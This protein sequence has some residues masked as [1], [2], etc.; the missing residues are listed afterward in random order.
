MAIRFTPK[1]FQRFSQITR[2]L[3]SSPSTLPVLPFNFDEKSESFV[4][5]KPET[6]TKTKTESS[7]LNFENTQELF[8]TFS[9]TKLIRSVFN[10]N[11]ASIDPVVDMGIWVMRSKLL[12]VPGFRQAILG[13]VKHSFYEQ[14]VAGKDLKETSETVQKLYGDGLRGMLNYGLEHAYDN[15]SCDQNYKTFLNTIESTK[16]FPPSSVSFVIVKISAICRMDLLEKISNLLRWEKQ[17][18]SFKLPWKQNSLPILSDSSPVYHTLDKPDPLTRQEEQDL[19]LAHERLSKLCQRCLELNVPLTVDAEDTK[20][21]PGIDYL[22]YNS[23]IEYNKLGDTPIVY[24]TLQAYLKDAKERMLLATK[25]A[26]K[27]GLPLGFKIVRGAYMSSESKLAASLGYES[28]IHNTI[29]D[30]HD[31]Y[32]DCASFMLDKIVNG[33]GAAVLATHNV[34]SGKLAATKARELGIG[35]ENERLQFAQL[36]G[37]SEALSYGLKNAGFQVSKYLTFGPVEEV[38]PYLLRRAEE[39]RGMLSSSNLDRQLMGMELKRR[40]KAIVGL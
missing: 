29:Q 5:K 18:P 13:S 22:T 12:D 26:E 23:A 10:L 39:N 32:N 35:K 2:P 15:D 1:L 25:A 33:S 34:E 11:M 19:E 8:P 27:M 28:P 30:T 14:F 9:T 24:G 40:M 36:Y 31:C 38:I 17:N 6:E 20:I 7:I 4:V 37:M 3:N 21:Q 16:L